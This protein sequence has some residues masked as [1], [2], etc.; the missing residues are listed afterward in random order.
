MIKAA[1]SHE[2]AELEELAT[3]SKLVAEYLKAAMQALDDPDDSSRRSSGASNRCRSL[4][5]TQPVAAEAGNPRMP[6][7]GAFAQWQPD[8]ENAAGSTQN[9]RHA[10]VCRTQRPRRL[11]PNRTTKRLP[12]SLSRL[13]TFNQKT[14]TPNNQGTILL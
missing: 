11:T 5:R 6:I 3:D 14:K 9:G 13:L 4:W 10:P 1:V 12:R 2:Q 7:P 8:T